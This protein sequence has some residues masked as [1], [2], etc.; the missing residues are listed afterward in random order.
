MI[1]SDLGR[2]LLALA[3]AVDALAQAVCKIPTQT[4]AVDA[5]LAR[6]AKEATAR[7]NEAAALARGEAPPGKRGD[8]KQAMGAVVPATDEPPEATIRRM[9]DDGEGSDGP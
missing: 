5:E 7:A 6:L 1:R 2:A 8:Y 4:A 3:A 9:R